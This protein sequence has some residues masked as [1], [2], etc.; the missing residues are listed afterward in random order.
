VTAEPDQLVQRGERSESTWATP[1]EREDLGLGSTWSTRREQCAYVMMITFICS[2]RN[3]NHTPSE[4]D[5]LGRVDYS[6]ENSAS[7]CATPLESIAL[8]HAQGVVGHRG[9]RR[10]QHIQPTPK[11]FRVNT[12]DVATLKS[13]PNAWRTAQLKIKVRVHQHVQR[14]DAHIRRACVRELEEWEA[15]RSHCE[16]STGAVRRVRSAGGDI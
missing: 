9:R 12:V 15:T 4:R 10:E 1:S 6:W 13:R 14:R 7:T 5:D 3:N 11:Y 2:C 16:Q 8:V